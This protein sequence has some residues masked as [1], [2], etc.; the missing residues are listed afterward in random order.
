MNQS[1][2][3]I[4]FDSQ[5]AVIYYFAPPPNSGDDDPRLINL[6][7]NID[8]LKQPSRFVYISTSG[9]Y[10]DHKGKEVDENTP[11]RPQTKRSKRR[12]AAEQTIQRWGKQQQVDT[13]ILRVGGIY[14][15]NRLPTKRIE[16]G[17]TVLRRDLSSP[18]NRIHAD[19][20]AQVC[21]AAAQ[22]P[23][24]HQIYNVCD[25]QPS[26]MSDYF[27]S[28]AQYAGLTPPREVDWQQAETEISPAML[29]Y[30]RE[31][32]R[33]NNNK[34]LNELNIKLQYPTLSDGLNSC[35]KNSN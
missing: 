24:G 10:G 17:I 8:P 3:A 14:G 5:G 2:S 29:S 26:S 18:T 13:V 27:F 12:L 32:R 20:L 31:S 30:L 1:L 22:A 35:F 34:M 6:L 25:M 16:Q 33:M 11:T 19:D 7:A 23:S 21:E 15:P 28:I 9:V 4:Q